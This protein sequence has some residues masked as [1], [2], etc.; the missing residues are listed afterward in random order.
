LISDLRIRH[1]GAVPLSDPPSRVPRAVAVAA[2]GGSA[3]S[4]RPRQGDAGL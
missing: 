2:A 1:G 3:Q 4:K